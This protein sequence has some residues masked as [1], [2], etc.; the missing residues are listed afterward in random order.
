MVKNRMNHLRISLHQEGGGDN[1][2]GMREIISDP[3]A[4]QE[5]AEMQHRSMKLKLEAAIEVFLTN[6]KTVN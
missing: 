4:S 5:C 3:S 1:A 2:Y 6:T